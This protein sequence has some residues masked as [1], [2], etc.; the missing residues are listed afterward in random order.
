MGPLQ[1]GLF[2][3]SRFDHTCPWSLYIC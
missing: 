3:S 1:Y 2:C